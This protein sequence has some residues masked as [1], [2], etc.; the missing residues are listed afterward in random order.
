[1]SGRTL[2]IIIAVLGLLVIGSLYGLKSVGTPVYNKSDDFAFRVLERS[3]VALPG[4]VKNYSRK[5]CDTTAHLI[6]GDEISRADPDLLFKKFPIELPNPLWNGTIACG[7]DHFDTM[8]G[9]ILRQQPL[10]HSRWVYALS[11]AD[12]R[13]I[14]FGDYR[15]TPDGKVPQTETSS[16]WFI[17]DNRVVGSI[18]CNNRDSVPNP[19]CNVYTYPGQGRYWMHLGFF[20]AVN[21]DKLPAALPVLTQ[22]LVDKLP[23]DAPADLIGYTVA[24]DFVLSKEAAKLVARFRTEL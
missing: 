9:N 20:P 23:D 14:G 22:M 24:D 16:L 10:N 6:V 7:Q 15:I 3:D 4:C 5:P 17:D 12:T 19:T 18:K 13:C 11:D 1:M 21:L 2:P 8:S